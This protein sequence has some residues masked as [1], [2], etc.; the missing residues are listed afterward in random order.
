MDSQGYANVADVLAWRKIKSLQTT[1][2]EILNAVSSSDKKRFALLHIPSAEVERDTPATTSTTSEDKR[3]GEVLHEKDA[4]TLDQNTAVPTTSAAQETATATALAVQDQNPSHF[5][6]RATQGHSIKSVEAESLLE[7]ISLEDKSK[8]PKTVVHGTFHG[9]WPAILKSGGLRSMNRNQVHFATGPTLDTVLSAQ[10]EGQAQ[11]NEPQVISGMRRDAQ[12]LIYINI[13]KALAA[14]CPFWRS[15]NDV[16]LSGGIA[17][18]NGDDKL[19]PLEFV[20]VVVERKRGMGKI[21]ENGQ[22]LQ[23]L[24][25]DLTKRNPKGNQGNKKN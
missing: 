22:V 6:I 1:F 24:P 15:E 3:E 20:D 17:S 8:L 7:K 4:I 14:G 23:E 10:P 12:I 21:W 2:P 25:A 19:V 5:L 9:A 11:S 18:G 13:E 16:I